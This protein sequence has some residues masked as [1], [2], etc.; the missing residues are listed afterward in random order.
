M[1][2][3]LKR[4]TTYHPQTDDQTEVVNRG[5]ETYLRCFTMQ[6]P[7]HWAKWLAWAEFSYNTNF[8]VAT[9]MTP[10]DIVYGRPPPAVLPYVA[11]SAT[12]SEVDTQLRDRDVMLVTLKANLLKAQQ[13]MTATANAKRRDVQ[14]AVDDW[15]YVKLRPYRHTSLFRHSHPKLAP[16]FIDPYQIVARVGAVAYCV[17]LPPSSN[18]HPVFH[19][20]VL[21]PALGP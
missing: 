11:D 18:I 17:A 20:S 10:F 4:S 6:A 5:I 15:V 21:R 9:N 1:G 14:F 7:T 12:V 3:Q 19:V 16:R 2:T 13:R 8:H